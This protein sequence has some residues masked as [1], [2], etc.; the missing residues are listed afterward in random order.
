MTDDVLE[1]RLPGQ[2]ALDIQVMAELDGR[3]ELMGS[4]CPRC[5]RCFYPPR[6]LCPDDLAE[7]ES[8]P[9]S[10]RGHVYAAVE[11]A[12]GPVGFDAPYW[13]AW[14]DLPEGVRVYTILDVPVG[15]SP[16]PG[17]PAELTPRVVRT[18]PYTVLGPVFRL[19]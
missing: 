13:V 1:V 17:L 12:R 18:E 2:D 7:S 16:E 5:S 4:R 3:W 11:V 19:V 6:A 14:V 10:R 15:R 8:V 9:L